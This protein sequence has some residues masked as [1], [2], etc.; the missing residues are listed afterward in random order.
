M[1][2][3]ENENDGEAKKRKEAK[4]LIERRLQQIQKEYN[5]RIISTANQ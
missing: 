1:N 4:L 3:S 5:Q 2:D